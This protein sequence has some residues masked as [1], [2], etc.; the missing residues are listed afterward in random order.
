M[1]RVVLP[2]DF[3][4]RRIYVDRPDPTGNSHTASVT[5]LKRYA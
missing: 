5:T 1:G 4:E 2:S 3:A